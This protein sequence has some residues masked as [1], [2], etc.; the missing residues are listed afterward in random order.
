MRIFGEEYD[1]R[2]HV[3]S[4]EGYSAHADQAELLSWASNFERDRLQ[5]MFL[6]HGEPDAIETLAGKLNE[7]H[8]S[9]VSIPD[10][11]RSY[12]F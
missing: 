12:T 9:N 2:A 8:V 6:V 10:L 7:Q 4:I 5:Q 3:E 11:N 1:V